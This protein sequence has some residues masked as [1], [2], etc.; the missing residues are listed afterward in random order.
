MVRAIIVGQVGFLCQSLCCKG[1]GKISVQGGYAGVFYEG[2]ELRRKEEKAR[3][4][5]FSCET[6]RETV[7]ALV[8]CRAQRKSMPTPMK[9]CSAK[10]G[11]I[12][13]D[14]STM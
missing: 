10:T 5:V 14:S 9:E 2:E 11:Q 4:T 13:P 12:E 6:L 8:Y 7:S 1:D 3:Y